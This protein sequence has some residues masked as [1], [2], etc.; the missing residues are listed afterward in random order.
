VYTIHY[1]QTVTQLFLFS[2]PCGLESYSLT[3]FFFFTP[4]VR[5][6]NFSHRNHRC[7][8]TIRKQRLSDNEKPHKIPNFPSEIGYI[9]FSVYSCIS[10]PLLFSFSTRK[11]PRRKA[12]FHFIRYG[13]VLQGF[14]CIVGLARRFPSLMKVVYPKKAPIYYYC[15]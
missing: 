9:Y 11:T 1:T 5:R 14:C 12:I 6:Y 13:S 10:F 3:V 15:T 8:Q 4:L 2:Y 7:R